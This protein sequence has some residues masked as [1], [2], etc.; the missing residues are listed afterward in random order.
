MAKPNIDQLKPSSAP[1]QLRHRHHLTD[2]LLKP[3][4]QACP[5]H[6]RDHRDH[7][8]LGKQLAHQAPPARTQGGTHR[9]LALPRRALGEQQVGNVGAGDE[10]QAAPAAAVSINML[11]RAPKTIASCKPVSS[12]ALP[13]FVSGYS[14]C[15]RAEMA[16]N[17]LCACSNVAPSANRPM[18]TQL[19]YWRPPAKGP[20]RPGRAIHTSMS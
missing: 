13:S 4:R 9:Q 14:A 6:A 20:S 17:W 19:W 15:K 10:Q 3:Q 8:A 18:G 16:S 7:Q 5:D 2:D 12:I 11:G 1:P